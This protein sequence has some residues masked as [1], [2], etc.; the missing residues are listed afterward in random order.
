MRLLILI[1]AAVLFAANPAESLIDQ[2]TAT[3]SSIDQHH[4]RHSCTR[5][6]RGSVRKQACQIR[7]V[8]GARAPGALRVATCESHL[9]PYARN[10]H[11]GA[12]GLFQFMPVHWRGRWNPLNGWVNTVHAYRASRH[13]THWAA[14]S[15]R[16]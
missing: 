1:L 2:G 11:S 5:F 14:W 15:C 13:G 4:R 12:A 10:R 7:K 8:F 3:V 6:P 16:P 9:N